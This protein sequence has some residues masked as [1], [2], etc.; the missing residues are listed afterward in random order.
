MNHLRGALRTTAVIVAGWSVT[1]V[2]SAGQA[3]AAEWEEGSPY[4][5]QLH[6]FEMLVS[7]AASAVLTPFVVFAA[8]RT[9]LRRGRALQSI[10][11]LLFTCAG[12]AVAR[13][14]LDM[15]LTELARNNFLARGLKPFA[16]V[17]LH[18]YF[19]SA[20]AIVVV[21]KLFRSWQEQRALRLRE[22]QIGREDARSRLQ[23]LQAD[24][25]P[26]FLFNT[27]NAAAA[28]V[29]PMPRAAEETIDALMQLLRRSLELSDRPSIAVREDVQFVAEYVKL[30]Q[31]R[32]GDRLRATI[33]VD[34]AAADEQVPPL[35][36]Q[37]LVENAVVHGI[38][39]RAEGGTIA[40]AVWVDEDRMRLQVKDDG[41][42]CDPSIVGIAPGLGISN[43]RARLECLFASDYRLTFRRDQAC[44]VA[45]IDIPRYHAAHRGNDAHLADDPGTRS[46][47][48]APGWLR[49]S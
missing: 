40:V 38:G 19:A 25:Q 6:L 46:L 17:I 27:L 41:P 13:A 21:T 8:D 32:F 42:G 15:T 31:V 20:V 14:A 30:Q 33:S 37:P 4:L 35:L 22:D 12:F 34:A 7:A 1:A 10:A 26:H 36:L 11:V 45:E 23:T 39:R 9:P 2:F 49:Q 28:L 48:P 44:F 5:F 29:A 3:Y 18:E 43:V 24:L 47:D 16:L